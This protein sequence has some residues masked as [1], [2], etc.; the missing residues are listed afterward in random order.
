MADWTHR[1]VG[2]FEILEV[3]GEGAEGQVFKA[4]SIDE[5][6]A[7]IAKGKLVAL[8]LL[9][10]TS[11]DQREEKRFR[12][13]IDILLSLN[14]PNIVRYVNSFILKP[15]EWDQ[16][17]WLAMEFLKGHNLKGL[18][19]QYPRGLPWDMAQSIF[20]QCLEGM[21]FAAEAGVVH[22]DIKPANIFVLEDGTV[23]LIDFGIARL[24][25]GGA[26][27]TAGDIKGAFD[28]MA[29][30]F[31]KPPTPVFSG[32]EQ[33]D[34]FSMG[35]VFYQMLTG[36]LPFPSLK[37]IPFVAYAERWMN[38]QRPAVNYQH[39][40]FWM[41][42]HS[43]RFAQR[44]L[45]LERAERF[46]NFRDMRETFSG[47]DRRV[48]RHGTQEGYR[49]LEFCG[50]GGFGEVYRAETVSSGRA[51]AV[52]VLAST[53]HSSRFEKE[54]QIL[55]NSGHP[56]IV[57]YLD[58]M[59]VEHGG[60]K[61]YYLVMEYLPGMPESTL[62]GRIGDEGGLPPEEAVELFIGYLDGLQHL[63]EAV[64]VIHRDIKPANLYAP[65][66][67]PAEAKI[68]DLGVA[69][70]IDPA[71]GTITS[72]QVPGTFDYMAPELLAG[73]SRGTPE[74][75]VFS[76]GLCLYEAL[77]AKTAFER[78]PRD[79]VGLAREIA[80]R[81]IKWPEVN[82][83]FW[84]FS[85]NPDLKAIVERS[86][87]FKPRDRFRSTGEMRE[88]LQA[89]LNRLRAEA[90]AAEMQE[91]LIEEELSR[92]GDT[93][94]L[95]PPRIPPPPVA[96]RPAAREEA[97]GEAGKAEKKAR[98]P[99]SRGRESG[100][101]PSSMIERPRTPPSDVLPEEEAPT[102]ESSVAAEAAAPG[103]EAAPPPA[104]ERPPPA[105]RPPPAIIFPPLI[106]PAARPVEPAAPAP[107]PSP[108]D[109]LAAEETLLP[110]ELMQPAPAVEPE[111]PAPEPPPPSAAPPRVEAPPPAVEEKAP[112]P[113][114]PERRPPRPPRP[115]I[116]IPWKA[117]GWT[118]SGIAALAVLG[119]GLWWA[120]G[121]IRESRL[122]S[123]YAA[124]SRFV[125]DPPNTD[126]PELFMEKAAR[127][128][129]ALDQWTARYPEEAGAVSAIASNMASLTARRIADHV[130]SGARSLA[131]AWDW[132]EA[133]ARAVEIGR[134]QANPAATPVKGE[135]DTSLQSLAQ[136]SR[137]RLARLAAEAVEKP[138]ARAQL[139]A[140]KD[141]PA[142]RPLL[143]DAY[144]PAVRASRLW[145]Q[146]VAAARA[147]ND[148]DAIRK[149]MAG[150]RD[151]ATNA[152]LAGVS[153]APYLAT[154]QK[155]FSARWRA[156][157]DAVGKSLS[158]KDLSEQDLAAADAAIGRLETRLRDQAKEAGADPQLERDLGALREL[159]QIGADRRKG[160]QEIM[161]EMVA[162]KKA[163]A[164]APGLEALDPLEKDYA[165]LAARAKP[166]DPL[167]KNNLEGL[168]QDLAARR[169]AI[170]QA[171]IRA[172][173]AALEKEIGGGENMEAA[174]RLGQ[175]LD[176]LSQQA[177]PFGDAFAA[178]LQRLRTALDAKRKEIEESL[179]AAAFKSFDVSIDGAKDLA[180]AGQL[181]PRL[182]AL[183]RQ[184]T[185]F[186]AKF[187]P[188]LQRLRAKL[189]GR[190]RSMEEA[191]F[192]AA[193][194]VLDREIDGA[195]DLASLAP[196]GPRTDALTSQAAS[197]GDA[198]RSEQQRLRAR[199]EAKRKSIEEALLAVAIDSAVSTMSKAGTALKA[200]ST[201]ADVLAV[202]RLNNKA[203]SSWPEAV[204][205]AERV[206]A[207][208]SEMA[209]QLAG[210]ARRLL[211]REPLATRAERLR[212]AAELLR[213]TDF[214][215][216]A[217]S[218]L[219]ATNA[220]A[221]L[222]AELDVFV[223]QVANES[224]ADVEIHSDRLAAPVVALKAGQAAALL[225]IKP[226]AGP[227][228]L[229]AR[230]G[231]GY[232]EQ[233]ADIPFVPGG[234]G[235][236]KIEPLLAQPV[237]V[238]IA[239]EPPPAS[240]S[241]A[242]VKIANTN[243]SPTAAGPG[244]ASVRLAPGRAY[245]IQ[246]LRADHAPVT[247][248]LSIQPGDTPTVQ[249]PRLA[250]WTP[251]D[252]RKRLA[253]LE[254]LGKPSAANAAGFGRL[255]SGEPP[256]FEWA[257]YAARYDRLAREW[258]G[259]ALASVST[260]VARAES[261]IALYREWLYQTDDPAGIPQPRRLAEPA[262]PAL[263]PVGDVELPA[264]LWT[265]NEDLRIRLQRALAW[266]GEGGLADDAKRRAAAA[267]LK[268]LS[269]G[270]RDTALRGQCDLE[271][272]LLAW[273]PTTPL[274][275]LPADL[276]EY[277]RWR[278]HASF[279]GNGD[280]MLVLEDLAFCA[281]AGPS[282]PMNVFDRRLALC[283]A[284][285]LWENLVYNP[286]N[287][288]QLERERE[289]ATRVQKALYA[290]LQQGA[291]DQV[292]AI[293]SYFEQ[294]AASDPL[295]RYVLAA[296]SLQPATFPLPD[297]RV[298]AQAWTKQN[299]D[300]VKSTGAENIGAL[301]GGARPQR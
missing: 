223:L 49:I 22:R 278:A 59:E 55:R 94:A 64:Q 43:S 161:R 25:D 207:A 197:L 289:A 99:V 170:R 211:E 229:V 234:A 281:G 246:F 167:F 3:L 56:R 210:Q 266:A 276:P 233:A 98:T 41:L 247:K 251:S 209:S 120:P 158:G 133:E 202:C 298:R 280:L 35:V 288:R 182:E 299:P 199:L 111:I 87:R 138:E 150:L 219:D 228:R 76:L 165:A 301:L 273:A 286:N 191:Q 109:R 24:R 57:T 245:E 293:A 34:V 172:A 135:L 10:R 198:F 294:G 119:F 274:P 225:E 101:T 140:L 162:L 100:V 171:P 156:E 231:K 130:A 230:R 126:P 297:L 44:A 257:E 102:E 264:R 164:D 249:G 30:D 83:S 95:P 14:H 7:G 132:S 258:E 141:S 271:S 243:L 106:K 226:G 127:H 269:A 27:T 139:A 260:D 270:V 159:R 215:A 12:R 203:R 201:P 91:T 142:L 13:Q 144:E 166:F 145:E 93:V 194:K 45:A 232:A 147:A 235:A 152:P 205:K 183:A 134:W 187:E 31:L 11:S 184:A 255:L 236:W 86:I 96:P 2:G 213:D 29:P 179:L 40:V 123:G 23:R 26:T 124:A 21:A 104:E 18:L 169:T 62:R 79:D 214:A 244:R 108:V 71:T 178:D 39:R 65:K 60:S 80:Q 131:A 176:A 188:E 261:A 290:V 58:F 137:T 190:K 5:T 118:A 252:G 50:R 113:R 222:K 206:N 284:G 177:A 238:Q 33:T 129:S 300:A 143:G 265:G 75:D 105:A 19:E 28:Y 110:E 36:K 48:I 4:V 52:K 168:A 38:P 208:V 192:T 296:L 90:A 282:H 54:A 37:G 32:D 117:I 9:A 259:S 88:A 69:R 263:P 51:V 151:A 200:A 122:K 160:I 20:A 81:L 181:A 218:V 78:F 82:F 220:A 279:V 262:P 196:L 84:I 287:A 72:G 239:F 114:P 295:R 224:G 216:A 6:A 189:D 241:P 67:R 268:A 180:A 46:P 1:K 157:A 89:V 221:R 227:A 92:T 285:R 267:R 186:G 242:A 248:S 277:R 85:I 195:N 275:E 153:A 291:S 256:R 136:E 115:P 237:E 250:D 15:G 63:H 254:A 154:L 185:P 77:V 272:A 253:A 292:T 193:V 173:I 8:K 42:R 283:A 74:S 148:Y 66:G 175:R 204:L 121:Y 240:E 125:T 107:A 53:G 17:F 217:A 68:F 97:P 116:R 163:V 212:Q 112:A 128:R 149:A 155:A 174:A 146:G 16:E 70:I 103:L 61:D 73:K 47:I